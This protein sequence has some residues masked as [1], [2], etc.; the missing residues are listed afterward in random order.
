MDG[1]KVWCKGLE[2]SHANIK[3]HLHKHVLDNV[4]S[5][6]KNKWEH[7]PNQATKLQN[8]KAKFTYTPL[9]R[10]K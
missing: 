2:R 5:F 4:E 8:E 3:F 9:V 10:P 1:M 7:S 6:F